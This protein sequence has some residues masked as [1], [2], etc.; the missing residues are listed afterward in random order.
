[1]MESSETKSADLAVSIA[2]VV[3]GCYLFKGCYL[4]SVFRIIFPK[5]TVQHGSP[6]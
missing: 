3:N 4:L 1:M 2:L 5:I 6:C